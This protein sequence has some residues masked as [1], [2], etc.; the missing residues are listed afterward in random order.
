MR[1]V[2]PVEKGPADS[3]EGAQLLVEDRKGWEP[4][5][6]QGERMLRA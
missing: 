1:P 6:S 4:L 3:K 5:R 2:E